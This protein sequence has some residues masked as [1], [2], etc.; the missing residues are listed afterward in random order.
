MCNWTR[1]L[2]VGTAGVATAALVTLSL[3]MLPS[4]GCGGLGQNAEVTSIEP[5]HGPA[6]GGTQITIVGSSLD[7]PLALTLNNVA[8]TNLQLIHSRALTAV[9]P[10]GTPGLA[11]L[12][13]IFADGSVITVPDAFTYDEEEQS[14]SEKPLSITVITPTSG[15]TA[16]GTELTIQGANFVAGSVLLIGGR[17]ASNLAVLGDSLMTATTPP[18]AEGVAEVTLNT[19]DGRSTSYPPGFTYVVIPPGPPTIT[20]ICPDRGPDAGGTVVRIEGASFGDITGVNFGSA[21]ATNFAKLSDTLIQAETPGVPAGT[22]TAVVA[23]IGLGGEEAHALFTYLPPGVT[24]ICGLIPFFGPEDGGTTVLINGS[25]LLHTESVTFGDDEGTDLDVLSDTQVIVKTPP[26]MGAVA[27]VLTTADGRKAGALFAYLPPITPP[28]LITRIDSLDPDHGPFIGGTQVFITGAGFTG[29]TSVTFGPRPGTDLNVVSDTQLT[30]KSP[31]GFG[32]VPV[33]VSTPHGDAVA[34]FTYEGGTLAPMVPV[35]AGEFQ[36]GDPWGEGGPDELPVHTV[37]VSSFMID[38]YEVTNALYC[39]FLNAGGN[40]DHWDSGQQILRQGAV[41][42]YTYS[43]APTREDHPVVYVNWEDAM[44]FCDWRSEAEGLAAGT[45]R[46]PTE[47]EREKAASWNPVTSHHYRFG[48]QTDGSGPDD[49]DGHRANY[50]DSGDPFEPRTTPVGYYDGTLYG[51]YQ[52]EDAYSY[53]GCYDMSGNVWEW[54]YDWYDDEYYSSSPGA[55][56]TGPP[57]GSYRVLRGGSWDYDANCC[58]AAVRGANSPAARYVNFG[59]RCAAG[60]P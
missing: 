45:Y 52:T 28:A 29:T 17:P 54:C 22:G 51:T 30:V 23:L 48:E 57:S 26:G 27:V 25:G 13:L 37:Y 59:F 19:S 12:A 47:A 8:A 56:P 7:M 1:S 14:T 24:T 55:D 21:S 44:A 2:R 49:L 42:P 4:G 32:T 33:I 50:S 41:A 6:S 36:M 11:T 34:L 39:Q 40:D 20:S 35:A 15:P 5:N 9:T 53:Y 60:A 31:Y 43:P 10:P 46:L 58:R 38:K 16:G 3:F 18:G